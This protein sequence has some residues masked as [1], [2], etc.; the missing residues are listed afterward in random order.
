M[1]YLFQSA[2]NSNRRY[3]TGICQLQGRE[4]ILDGL[5]GR[6]QSLHWHSLDLVTEANQ[7]TDLLGLLEK[8][9]PVRQPV[10][11]APK[12]LLRQQTRGLRASESSLFPV[13]LSSHIKAKELHL[14]EA[15]LR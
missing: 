5:G 11:A 1:G 2:E 15:L 9:Q 8:A 3:L 14:E 4:D 13:R 12:A 6:D 10:C 7:H